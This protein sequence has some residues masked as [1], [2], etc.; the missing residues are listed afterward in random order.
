MVE[1]LRYAAFADPQNPGGGNPAGVVPDASSLTEV[2]M[3]AIAADVGYSETAFL[4]GA[5]RG[6]A[7]PSPRLRPHRSPK[8]SWGSRRRFVA[9]VPNLDRG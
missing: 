8:V 1:V 6:G 2:E 7:Q 5:N 9:R 4:T 3:Q